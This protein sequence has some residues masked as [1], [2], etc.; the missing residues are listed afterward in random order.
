[1]PAPGRRLRTAVRAQ[2]NRVLVVVALLVL[3]PTV[4]IGERL[5]RGSGCHILRWGVSIVAT[6]CGVRFAVRGHSPLDRH[7]SVVVPNHSSPMDIPALLWA[8]SDIRFLAAA[9]LFR[10]PVL[11]AAMRAVGTVPIDRRD[12]DRAQGQLDQLVDDRRQRAGGSIAVFAEGAIAPMGRRLPFKSGAFSLAI[13]TA[14]PV[15]PV[16]IHGSDRVLPPRGRLLVRPGMVTIEFLE[17]IDTSGLT[18]EDRHTLRDHVHV[19][20]C[21]AVGGE[22]TVRT[23]NS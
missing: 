4:V 14:T 1:V 22:P 16:A 12:H 6:M 17:A 10:I 19:L 9:D 23:A 11:A 7:G 2:C 20:V 13:R 15:V 3:L 21:D 5:R 8:D 18:L